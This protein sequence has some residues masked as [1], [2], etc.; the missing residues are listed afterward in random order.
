MLGIVVV[1]RDS[2]VTQKRKKLVAIPLEAI[3]TL[4]CRVTLT[5]G[6]F[7]FVIK[8][9]HIGQM[10]LQKV[11]LEPILVNGLDNLFQQNSESRYNLFQLIVE[12]IVQNLV[13]QVPHQMD[14]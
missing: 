8:A 9:F 2:I 4:Q 3:F 12:G 14:E 11:L 1:P 5:I 7:K 6:S 10:F 13:V